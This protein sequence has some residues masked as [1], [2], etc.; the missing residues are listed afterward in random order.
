MEFLARSAAQTSIHLLLLVA[1]YT[2]N[3]NKTLK[4][5]LV[6]LT[7]DIWKRYPY[8]VCIP[9]DELSAL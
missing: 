1:E 3:S 5:V 8:R 6:P 4:K 7:I 2:N 9:K